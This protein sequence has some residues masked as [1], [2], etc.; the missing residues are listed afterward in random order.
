[1]WKIEKQKILFQIRRQPI[2]Y[3]SFNQTDLHESINRTLAL[4]SINTASLA[5]RIGQLTIFFLFRLSLHETYF[6]QYFLHIK[7]F[8]SWEFVQPKRC[9]QWMTGK[10]PTTH[11]T[12]SSS[13]LRWVKSITIVIFNNKQCWHQANHQQSQK[14]Y[15]SKVPYFSLR[16]TQCSLPQRTGRHRPWQH[17]AVMC[18]CSHSIMSGKL[19]L[20][21]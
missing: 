15:I 13:T 21:D 8:Q 7:I 14:V 5:A 9:T 19:D 12:G 6:L 10:C 11:S 2:F 20:E 17:M 4:Y 3:G 18:S 16:V 1:M